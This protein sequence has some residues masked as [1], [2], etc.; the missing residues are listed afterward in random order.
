MTSHEYRQ[1]AEFLL[2]RPR[3]TPSEIAQADVW[4][5]LAQAAAVAE[6]AEIAARTRA[7]DLV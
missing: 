4:A 1:R 7:A 2:N 3:V 6:A 5:R